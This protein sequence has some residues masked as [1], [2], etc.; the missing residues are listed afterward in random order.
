MRGGLSLARPAGSLT[1]GLAHFVLGGIQTSLRRS[2]LLRVPDLQDDL[3]GHVWCAR[4][5][6][7]RLA[8]LQ[9]RQ[10]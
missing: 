9:E 5:H 7:L 4:K 3:A 8:R 1:D 2:A 6:G 10:D